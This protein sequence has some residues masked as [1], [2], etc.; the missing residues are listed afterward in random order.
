MAYIY[1]INFQIQPEQMSELH[2]GAAL[3]RVLGYLRTLLPAEPG[4]VATR[5]MYS[6][7][8]EEH[9]DLVFQSVWELW[10]DLQNHLESGL[11]ENKA[12]VEFGPHI[13]VDDLVVRVYREVR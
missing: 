13:S 3:E 5:A 1:Q 6:M 2:I 10:E 8:R 7:D 9:T 12:L 4:Y 11:V